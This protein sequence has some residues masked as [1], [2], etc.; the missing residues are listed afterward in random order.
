M[1]TTFTY[2]GTTIN[3]VHYKSIEDECEA[4]G[5]NMNVLIPDADE[6]FAYVSNGFL[7]GLSKDECEAGEWHH[8]FVKNGTSYEA[9]QMSFN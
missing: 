9:K 5:I 6:D 7:L 4:K 2:R 1:T 8:Y 3:K